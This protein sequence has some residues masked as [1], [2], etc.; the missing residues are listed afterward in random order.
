MPIEF[1]EVAPPSAIGQIKS[2][3]V[4]QGGRKQLVFKL[5]NGEGQAVDLNREVENPPA[6]LPDW[7]PQPQATGNN[8]SVRL[9][10]RAGDLYGPVTFDVEGAKLAE[11]G[12]VSFQITELNTAYP[13][14]FAATIGEFLPG[15]QIVNTWPVLVIVEA[16]AFTEL[17]G[18]GPLTIPEIRYALLDVENG[19]AG[20]PFNNLIDD[21]EFTDSEIIFAMRRIVDK[22]NE[23]PP[24][25]AYYTGMSFPYR[26]WWLQG[27]VAQLLIMGAARYRRNRLAY[28]AGGISIDDQSKS[29]EYETVG[30][31][32]MQEFDQWML[33]EK[34]RI[35]MTMCWGVSL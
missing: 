34:T 12:F 15:G 1:Y 6:P 24:P 13:G 31:A 5:T 27:T 10:A 28:A 20:A 21:V 35:N 8:T 16:N 7:S 9:R 11:E 4:P 2:V 3:R 18:V 14:A 29:E 19:T 30:R 33:K 23:T 32:T 22:W 25:V 17:C 26:Y